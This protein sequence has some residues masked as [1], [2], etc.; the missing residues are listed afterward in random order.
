MLTETSA[1]RL[2]NTK[3]IELQFFTDDDVPDYAILSHTWDQEEVLFQDIGLESA[4][5]K[6]GYNKLRNCCRVAEQNGFDYIWDDT[7]CIDKASSA[8][9]SEAIN[10]MYRY[11][12]EANVCYVYLA[13]VSTTSRIPDSRWFTRGWTLQELIAPH[14]IIFFDQHWQELGTKTSLV[15]IL[16]E[17]T[18]IPQYILSDSDDLETTSIAQRMSWAADRV[19]TRK[20]DASS[21]W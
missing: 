7:C 5:A 4:K 13:D 15:R 6:K 9:L 2:I 16:S 1:M 21:L 18:S 11:Y 14:E 17:R 3:S 19:T 20:E 12:Q 10:S 8:E